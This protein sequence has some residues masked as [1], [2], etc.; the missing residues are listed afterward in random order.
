MIIDSDL[1]GDPGGSTLR[2]ASDFTGR[3]AIVVRGSGVRL[4]GFSIEGNR[5]TSD[6]RAGLPPYDVPFARFTRGN[7]ILVDGAADVRI[8]GIDLREIAGFAVL[9]SASR[10]ISIDR[11]HIRDSGSRDFAGRNNTTGG[12]L[13]EAGTTDFLVARSDFRNV[14]GNG[15]WTHSIYTAPRNAR[16]RF[17]E[18]TFDTIGR[19]ALQVGHAFE[20]RVERNSGKA[21]GYPPDAVDAT[22]VAIDTAGNVER[23]L[24]SH[25]RFEQIQGKCI[26]LD[27]FH[28]GDVVGNR[29][30][31]VR[32]YGVVMNNTNPDMQSQNIRILA[33]DLD[34]MLYGGIFVIGTGHTVAQNRLSHVNSGRCDNCIF[35]PDE[36]EMLR[37]GIYLGRRA[38]RAAP[39]H[40]NLIEENQISG[41]KMT[42]RCVSSAPG[43]S[44]NIVRNNICRNDPQ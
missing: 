34:G 24:Y 16:G 15:L 6:A 3:A 2:I 19:D 28:D 44:G 27:G 14:S 21:I 43:I 33:N 13:L 11:V 40:A 39:A 29:C 26:D 23:S 37:S 20:V 4:A 35:Q 10:E 25:N 9:V 36:P 12:I 22:P 42:G 17:V 38:E 7:G 30:R 32:G 18:N 5:R 1:A 41:Y 8:D 31:D